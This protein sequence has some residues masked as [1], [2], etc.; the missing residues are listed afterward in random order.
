[1][2]RPVQSCAGRYRGIYP[3]IAPILRILEI[4]GQMPLDNAALQLRTDEVAAPL[5]DK[6]HSLSNSILR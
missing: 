3:P 1:M 4:S 2:S 6:A 5:P